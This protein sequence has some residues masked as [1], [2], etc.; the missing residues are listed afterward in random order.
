MKTIICIIFSIVIVGCAKAP[1]FNYNNDINSVVVICDQFGGHGTGW[2]IGDGLI[3]TAKHVVANTNMTYYYVEKNTDGVQKNLEIVFKS[4]FLDFA[5][6]RTKHEHNLTPVVLAQENAKV[7]DSIFMIGHP[8]ELTWA[9][10]EGYVMQSEIVFTGR[11]GDYFKG[12]YMAMNIARF[13]GSSGSCVWNSKGEVVGLLTAML[14]D[15]NIAIGLSL[16]SI[17][18]GF[19]EMENGK[20]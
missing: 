3:V 8:Q 9:Y 16:N 14:P 6:L 10:S 11:I 13:G 18:L 4:E 2:Y 1:E 15:S 5:V 20:N 7:G 17:K 12:E 19:K